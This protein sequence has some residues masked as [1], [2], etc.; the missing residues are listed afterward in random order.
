MSEAIL[1]ADPLIHLAELAAL[2]ALQ[3]FTK[4]LVPEIV[5]LEVQKY[6][7]DALEIKA[8]GFETIKIAEIPTSL[9]ALGQALL[10]DQG[11]LDAL[12]LMQ[13]HPEAVFLTDD[14]AARLAAEQ[15][16]FR[17][18]GTIGLLI[19]M[20]RQGLRKPVDVIKLLQSIPEKST[21]HIRKS[22]LDEVVE[23]L[24][25]EWGC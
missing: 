15:M 8:P 19:R 5:T 4:V 7:P 18:H 23:N 13:L 6:R 12:A 16:G 25:S 24:R 2:D 22:L 11:E 1:D 20:V 9:F 10:L 3:G 21:L 17:A 14:S